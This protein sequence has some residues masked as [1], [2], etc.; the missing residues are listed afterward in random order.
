MFNNKPHKLHHFS[1]NYDDRSKLS[2]RLADVKSFWTSD[3]EVNHLVVNFKD[4]GGQVAITSMGYEKF[5]ELMDDF[6]NRSQH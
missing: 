6:E 4:N 1:C 2:F 5:K 3:F